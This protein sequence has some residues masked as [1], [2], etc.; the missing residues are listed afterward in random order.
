MPIKYYGN[1]YDIIKE[2]KHIHR[3]VNTNIQLA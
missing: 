3:K 1:V 2:I